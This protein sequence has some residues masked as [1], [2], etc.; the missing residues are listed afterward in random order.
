MLDDY[1]ATEIIVFADSSS[2]LYR[3]MVG[4]SRRV[5]LLY[6]PLCVVFIFP[7]LFHVVVRFVSLPSSWSV[8]IR[9]LK[10]TVCIS[11]W[12]WTVWG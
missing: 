9:D 2:E 11:S 7:V 1:I 5:P 8:E 6:G 10:W 4:R 3:L 12:G